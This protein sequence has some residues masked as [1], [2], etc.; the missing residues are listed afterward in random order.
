MTAP[1]PGTVTLTESQLSQLLA[2]VAARSAAPAARPASPQRPT[3]EETAPLHTLSN[4]ELGRRL[5]RALSENHKSPWW[6]E[7]SE[8]TGATPAAPGVPGLAEQIQNLPTGPQSMSLLEALT[9]A[10]DLHSPGWRPTG[11]RGARTI[12][13]A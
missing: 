4:D 9:T 12:F 10:H 3:V 1:T 13:D 2:A 7:V 6:A 5:V 11:A 8:N